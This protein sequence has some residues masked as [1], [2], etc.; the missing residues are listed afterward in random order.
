MKYISIVL[1]IIAV[2][3]MLVGLIPCLGW[4]NWILTLPTAIVGF[5]IAYWLRSQ[6]EENRNDSMIKTGMMLNVCA[7][8]IGVIKLI[9][10]GG[11]F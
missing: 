4:L 1:G 2:L 6:S 7:L 9:V 8:I 10:G 11:F 3:F 5:L